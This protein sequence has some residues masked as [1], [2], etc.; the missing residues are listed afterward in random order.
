MTLGL[1]GFVTL[2][3]FKSSLD[4]TLNQKSKTL[5][6][7]D[8]GISAR[9]PLL[10]NEKQL[11][12]QL[13]PQ[14][15]PQIQS[16]EMTELYSMVA[17]SS[18]A[19]R[20][21][22]IKAIQPNY[23]FYGQF[24]LEKPLKLPQ[25]L[26]P[27]DGAWVYPEVLTQLS[28]KIGDSLRIG[29]ASFKITNVIMND[30]ASGFSTTLS[31]RI[32]IPRADLIQTKL[33]RPGSIAWH[34]VLYKVPGQ[35]LEVLEGFRDQ[36]FKEA[37]END[38]RTYTHK[39]TSEQMGRLLNYLNDFLGLASIAALFLASIGS[40]FLFRSF[41][42]KNSRQVA[43][44]L[45]LG[46]SR[47]RSISFYIIQLFF[48][49]LT[50]ALLSS[51]LAL[52]I[53][54]ISRW[55]VQSVVPI[56]FILHIQ[57]SS[58]FI[59]LLVG[60]VGGVL[61]CLPILSSLFS[62]K[63]S[64]LFHENTFHSSQWSWLQ[65][66][67]YLPI[68]LFF[69]G[70]SVWLANS[71]LVGLSFI[72]VFLITLVLLSFAGY[73][74]LI[75][76][77]A[78]QKKLSEQ[79]NSSSFNWALRDLHKLKLSSLSAFVCIGLGITL[80][81]II[82]Q[83]QVTLDHELSLPAGK[84]LPSLFL[85]DIQEEQVAQLKEV[86]Q[87]ED[88]TLSQI[89]PMIRGRISTVNGQPFDKGAGSNSDDFSR[90]QQRENRFRNRG[91]N[92]S[93][94]ARLLDSEKI[95]EGTDFSGTFNPEIDQRAEVSIEKRYASRLKL[96]LGDNITFDVESIL[97]PA[98]IV[99][100]RSVKWTSFE[101]NFFI[102]LQPGVLEQAPKTF[103]A[104]L[105]ALSLEKRNSI[106]NRLVE[107]LPNVSIIDVSR[108]A[109]RLRKIIQQMG[110]AL[111]IM[112]IFCL[113]TGFAVLF[114]IA[115]HQVQERIFDIGLLKVLGASFNDIRNSFLIQFS[116]ITL[117]VSLL[118]VLLSFVL[119]YLLTSVVFDST[120]KVSFWYP[121]LTWVGASLLSLLVTFFATKTSLKIS[122]IRLL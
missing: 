107:Q 87:S 37:Q 68:L 118:G 59:A 96:K 19:S 104:T 82:P 55:A 88:L 8:L 43:I 50:S 64:Q 30:P 72:V 67:L 52:I 23:P 1:T 97:I 63:A 6:G 40:V 46:F 121:L 86:V 26:K 80:L 81:N 112:S 15:T 101:P 99:N 4:F 18:G 110:F 25:S 3:F 60:S 119:S 117:T 53:L 36:V 71:L 27:G 111:Q 73:L 120:W 49:G 93:Y 41:I 2:D 5:L 17:S 103:I 62:L 51:L 35:N 122:P 77:R 74:F 94:R 108:T 66:S 98:K 76:L 24:E 32:Y 116:V 28:L 22:Q 106:Q 34:S 57:S 11:I 83:I 33:I 42:R 29:E 95:I 58:L 10:K 84:K 65:L 75:L 61:A 90:E 113:L 89:S 31:S 12:Q 16:T 114:S 105:P 69:A 79:N 13:N 9:R 92:L 102:Q 38:L 14:L 39:D 70:L 44:L 7:A 115:N 56:E 78:L 21:F 20:L 91:I 109:E 47:A 85:F 45:A 48:L 100:I 54:P